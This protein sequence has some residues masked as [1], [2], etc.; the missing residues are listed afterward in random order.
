MNPTLVQFQ[1]GNMFFALS[2]TQD[3]PQRLLLVR[4]ALVAFE[5]SQVEFHLPFVGRIKFADLQIDR[6]Q[7]AQLTMVEQ[8]IEIIVTV[9]NLHPLLSRNKT[10][11]VSQF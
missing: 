11:A 2:G 10:E 6:H 7:P 4:L 3:D 5:P 8:Q 9:V 1:Q